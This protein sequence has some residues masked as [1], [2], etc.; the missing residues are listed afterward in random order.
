MVFEVLL[1]CFQVIKHMISVKPLISNING[2][3]DLLALEQH[4][5]GSSKWDTIVDRVE[6][7]LCYQVWNGINLC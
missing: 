1:H 7:I 3:G 6:P 2:C 5:T 4:N